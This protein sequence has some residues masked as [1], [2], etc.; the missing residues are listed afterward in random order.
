MITLENIA[1]H[2]LIGLETK[3]VDSSN[4]QIIG[5]NGK[6]V[7]ETKSMF[8]IKTSNGFKKIPKEQNNWKFSV[9]SEEIVL[10]GSNLCKRP[11]DRVGF[12]F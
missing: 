5:L 11:F 1:L 10:H 3:I 9:Q 7:D 4:K 6:V 8:V 12:K 2:E